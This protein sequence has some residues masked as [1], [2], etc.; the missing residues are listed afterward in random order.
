M[1]GMLRPDRPRISVVIPTLNAG[2]DLPRTLGALADAM[3]DGLLREVIVSDGGSTDQTLEVAD[4]AGCVILRGPPGRGT[5]I[6]AGTQTARADWLLILHADTVPDEDWAAIAARHIETPGGEGKA[7]VF[8]L[9]FSEGGL[10]ARIVATGANARTRLFGLPY[11]DQGLLIHRALLEEVGSYRA[12][13]L[14]E[15]VDLVRRIGRV[16]LKVLDAICV[17]NSKRYRRDGWVRRSV[18]NLW[19][20]GRFLLGAN[21][22]SLAREYQ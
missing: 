20:L 21:P 16:R 17:T 8:R 14:M 13:P 11:G 15:D 5:Q 1:G 10:R 9:K 18:A 2:D 19:L 6:L 12:I 7:G 4:D 3:V 22:E